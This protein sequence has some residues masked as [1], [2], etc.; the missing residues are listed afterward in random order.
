MEVAPGSLL[1]S[2]QL[3]P[4]IIQVCLTQMGMNAEQSAETTT[5]VLNVLNMLATQIAPSTQTSPAAAASRPQPPDI[6]P[7]NVVNVEDDKAEEARG[8]DVEFTDGSTDT[9]AEAV[10]ATENKPYTKIKKRMSKK[11]RDAKNGKGAQGKGDS[12]N[13]DKDKGKVKK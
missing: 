7:V 13:T 2:S 8:E 11:D 3:D 6:V 1:H 10:A 12:K 5:M 9:A 4:A